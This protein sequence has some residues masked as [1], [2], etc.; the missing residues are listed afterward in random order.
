M[1]K[2]V[3]E[4]VQIISLLILAGV[5]AE[6]FLAEEVTIEQGVFRIVVGGF[7]LGIGWFLR[8]R[9]YEFCRHL[10]L[11]VGLVIRYRCVR[12][13]RDI[14]YETTLGFFLDGKPKYTVVTFLTEP[15][16]GQECPLGIE[17]GSDTIRLLRARLWN[18][19]INYLMV[20][21]G[22]ILLC[23][24]QWLGY[25]F[26]SLFLIGGLVI[27]A[28]WGFPKKVRKPN[29]EQLLSLQCTLQERTAESKILEEH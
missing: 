9:R 28:V 5:L 22:G 21:G 29:D 14:T 23:P 27:L 26:R 24:Q 6:M 1:K 7:L 16:I 17:P 10:F 12:R 13:G 3:L 8:A 2:Y 18:T 11:L 15:K 4:Y 20:G 25:Y 19:L